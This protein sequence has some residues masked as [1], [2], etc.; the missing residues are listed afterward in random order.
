MFCINKKNVSDYVLGMYSYIYIIELLDMKYSM[1]TDT[2]PHRWP[3]NDMPRGKCPKNINTCSTKELRSDSE[4][5]NYSSDMW[6]NY[7]GI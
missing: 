6:M 5:N 7:M 3:H 4:I 1:H 2:P